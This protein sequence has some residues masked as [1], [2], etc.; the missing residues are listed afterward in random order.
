MTD[1]KGRNEPQWVSPSSMQD[2]PPDYETIGTIF[3]YILIGISW[4]IIVLTF[5]FSMCFCLKVIKEYERVVIFRIG[6]L[7]FGGA[8]G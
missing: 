3:G 6:R 8:R 1:A 5:P 7:V 2:V 4:I